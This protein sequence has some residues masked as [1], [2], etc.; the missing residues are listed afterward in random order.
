MIE[1]MACGTFVIA[2]RQGSAS[3]IIDRGVTGAV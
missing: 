2:F 3:E 1:A